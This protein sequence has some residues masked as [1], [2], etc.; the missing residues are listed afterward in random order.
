MKKLLLTLSACLAVSSISFAQLTEN[1]E[2]TTGSAL[3]AGWSQTVVPSSGPN[4][5]VGWN[6]GTNATLAST[7]FSI[8]AH[9]RFVAVNDDKKAGANNSSSVLYTPIFS[10]V[11]MTSPYLSFDCS[12]LHNA[13]GGFYEQAQVEIST[14]GGST[15]NLVDTLAGNTVYWWEPRNMSLGSFAASATTQLRFTYKDN[16]GW[17][18]GWAIDNV[19]VFS[20][21][22]NDIALTALAPATGS[23]NSY[24]LGGSNVTITG[25]V[26]NNGASTITSYNVVYVFNGGAPVVNTFTG[27]SI[28]PFTTAT[29]TATTPVTLPTAVGPYQ[30]QAMAVLPGDANASNDTS[31]LDTLN[32]A[33][34]MP[35]KKLAIE[36]GTGTW[37][38][39]C[40]RGAVY[41]DSLHTLYGDNVSL[42]A[43]H[44]N[45]P[46]EVTAYDAWMGSQISGYPSVVID[47]R[48][49]A[50]PSALLQVYTQHSSDFAFADVTA[51]PTLTGST[52]SVA[53]TVKPAINIKNARLALVLTE[54]EV[55]GTV[56]GYNQTN[57]YSGSSSAFLTGQGL[58]YNAL[59]NPI[60]AAQMYFNHVGRSITPSATGGT[61]LLP[62]SMTYSTPYNYTFSGVSLDPTWVRGYVHGIVLLIDGSNGAVLNSQN[63]KAAVGIKDLEAGIANM[64]VVPNPATSEATIRLDLKTASKV[65]VEISDIAGRSVYSIPATEC[66]SGNNMINIPLNNFATGL[67]NVKVQ[68]ESGIVTTKLNVVK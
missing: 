52:L 51:V 47:R 23:P 59:P 50:D 32:T 42:V 31:D 8:P 16:T 18:Y 15:W 53:V 36:E 13:Y 26:F 21:A 2:S 14:D 6:S 17:E 25:S 30:L 65:Q 35:T 58:N 38:G 40:P 29:F 41:M 39:W 20:A 22:A 68:T 34:F 37:C 19:S 43:V 48:M 54:D 44:N 64:M 63:F 56:A 5:S 7:D 4:D 28:A 46:M 67:Y 24:G 11:G 12:F 60:P 66:G 57:Y 10:T 33:A 55:H 9:T 49:V 62:A 45:D 1:F 27:V 3:P 61:G